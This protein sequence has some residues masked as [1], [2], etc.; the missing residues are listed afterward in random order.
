M[1]RI[2]DL[3]VAFYATISGKL[4]RDQ[5]EL[6]LMA[7][8]YNVTNKELESCLADLGVRAGEYVTFDVFFDWWTS[9]VGASFLRRK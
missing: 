8:G 6:L 5:F 3:I 9:S 7:V 1:Q 2:E 4:D